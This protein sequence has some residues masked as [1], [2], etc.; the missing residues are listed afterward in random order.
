MKVP[1]P[2]FRKHTWSTR[3]YVVL[4]ILASQRLGR[5]ELGLGTQELGQDTQTAFGV[6][7]G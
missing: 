1:D 3:E 6:H 2:S 4:P 7:V 5:V